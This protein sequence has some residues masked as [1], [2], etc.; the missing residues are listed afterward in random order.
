MHTSIQALCLAAASGL[1]SGSAQA[2]PAPVPTATGAAGPSLEQLGRLPLSFPAQ[3]TPARHSCKGQ[4]SCVGQ[5]G[6]KAGDQGCK[7]K[8]TCKGKGGCSTMG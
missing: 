1:L 7:A 3:T 2:Q 4:N 5:G 8:N 6:C